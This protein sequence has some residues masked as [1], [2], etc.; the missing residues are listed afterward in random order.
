[1]ELENIEVGRKKEDKMEK[2]KRDKTFNGALFK[3]LTYKK[4]RA[5]FKYLSLK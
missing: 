4:R 2:N 3:I 5:L 1:M